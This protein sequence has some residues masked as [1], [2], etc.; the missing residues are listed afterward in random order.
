MTNTGQAE[1]SLLDF[2]N[3]TVGKQIDETAQLQAHAAFQV[4]RRLTQREDSW[5]LRVELRL[6]EGTD[7]LQ[8]T[9]AKPWNLMTCLLGS[10]NFLVLLTLFFL[11]FFLFIMGMSIVYNQSC[12]AT[13]FEEQKLYFL[14]IMVCKWKGIL[15]QDVIYQDYHPYLIKVYLDFGADDI[16]KTL[17]LVWYYYM[18]KSLGDVGMG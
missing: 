15:S 4:K 13:E 2:Q 11:P 17:D 7:E 16:E 1:R 8:R 9:T 3:S 10:Q 5:A 6:R 14:V 12:P 18:L